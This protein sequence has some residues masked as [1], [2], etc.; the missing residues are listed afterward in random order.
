MAA[1]IAI[2]AVF[3]VPLDVRPSGGDRTVDWLGAALVTVG[4]I[5]LTFVLADGQTASNGVSGYPERR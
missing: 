2:T 3:T 4:L 5:L 1:A